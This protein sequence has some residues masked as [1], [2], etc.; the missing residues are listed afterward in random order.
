MGEGIEEKVARCECGYRDFQ[1]ERESRDSD[2]E[3]DIK[4]FTK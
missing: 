3:P 2:S 4:K 1:A